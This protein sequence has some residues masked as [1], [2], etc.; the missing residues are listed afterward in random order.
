MA[1]TCLS[2]TLFQ[3]ILN[4]GCP[5]QEREYG[6][7]KIHFELTKKGELTTKNYI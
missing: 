3:K 6:I 4:V 2:Q 1:D 7:F 5:A